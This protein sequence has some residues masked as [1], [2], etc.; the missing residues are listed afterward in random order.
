MIKQSPCFKASDRKPLNYEN[1]IFKWLKKQISSKKALVGQ[2]YPHYSAVLP[3][4]PQWGIGKAAKVDIFE[5][6]I[7]KNKTDVPKTSSKQ[8]TE[9]QDIKSVKGYISFDSQLGRKD[10]SENLIFNAHDQRFE[11]FNTNP[12]ISTSHE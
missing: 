9:K 7:L 10:I 11:P 6:I 4:S 12:S 3:S 8:E 5:E 1:V 2:Y